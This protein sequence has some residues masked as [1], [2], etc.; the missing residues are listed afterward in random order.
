MRRVLAFLVL[1]GMF[2]LVS[3]KGSLTEETVCLCAM[4]IVVALPNTKE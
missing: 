2:W 3:G 1:S 4:L